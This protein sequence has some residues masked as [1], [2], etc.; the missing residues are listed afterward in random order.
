MEP[1][2]PRSHHQSQRWHSYER[3][4]CCPLTHWGF[5]AQAEEA[6]FSKPLNDSVFP[7]TPLGLPQV[8]TYNSPRETLPPAISA[9]FSPQVPGIWAGIGMKGLL[10]LAGTVIS[11]V[12]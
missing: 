1:E 3:P 11:L 10:S 4:F 6:Y 12:L 2:T 7:A 9:P 8:S 5:L